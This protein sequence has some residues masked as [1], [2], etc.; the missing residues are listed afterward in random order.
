MVGM[1]EHEKASHCF[2]PGSFGI[3]TTEKPE[4]RDRSACQFKEET[5]RR[6]GCV[7]KWDHVSDDFASRFC[8]N[9]I[10][11]RHSAN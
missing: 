9:V 8:L 1:A 7:S 11:R 5:T 3:A 10:Y 2:W 4:Q 6:A